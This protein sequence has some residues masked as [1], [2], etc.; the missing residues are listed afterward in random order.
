[1]WA[2]GR[3]RMRKKGCWTSGSWVCW[4]SVSSC[5]YSHGFPDGMDCDPLWARLSP[6]PL[7]CSP[8]ILCRNYEKSNQ[9]TLILPS[10]PISCPQLSRLLFLQNAP[11]LSASLWGK[12]WFCLPISVSVLPSAHPVPVTLASLQFLKLPRHVLTSGPLPLSGSFCLGGSLFSYT[13]GRS[14]PPSGLGPLSAFVNWPGCLA[15]S[16]LP[17]LGYNITPTALSSW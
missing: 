15:R 5:F 6:T 3:K 17:A 11:V 2:P 13:H 12:T 9:Y 7:S 8:Q 16:P 1:M 4:C 14:S 10:S